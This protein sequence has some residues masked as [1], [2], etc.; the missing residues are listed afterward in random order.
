[1]TALQEI[2]GLQITLLRAEQQRNFM[3]DDTFTF[4]LKVNSISV[5]FQFQT[6]FSKKLFKALF[7][8]DDFAGFLFLNQYF[9]ND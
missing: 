7:H 3:I 4:A 2:Q 6:M 8:I 9:E 1:M 5:K